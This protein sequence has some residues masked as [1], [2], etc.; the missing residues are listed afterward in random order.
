MLATS[1]PSTSSFWTATFWEILSA[2]AAA[3]GA[4]GIGLAWWG[5]RD[6]AKQTKA[7]TQSA[8]VQAWIYA[9]TVFNEDEFRA[10][11]KNI[12]GFASQVNGRR[13][14]SNGLETWNDHG[15]S[16]QVTYKDAL[17]AAALLN[18]CAA[19]A[20]R[21]G[22]MDEDYF[23]ANW[24][25]PYRKAWIVLSDVV[26]CEREKYDRPNIQGSFEHAGRVAL[27]HLGWPKGVGWDESGDWCNNPLFAPATW[28]K[29]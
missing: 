24:A 26:R 3:I 25:D 1:V 9:E 15:V 11:R 14:E 19:F 12:F 13:W 8:M 22:A 6:L 4:A 18:L 7:A 23:K 17:K 28:P 16:V 5:L 2:L 20:M 21:G 29:S 10:L 27:H